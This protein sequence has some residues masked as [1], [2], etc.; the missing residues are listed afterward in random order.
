MEDF[1]P[2]QLKRISQLSVIAALQCEP[3]NTKGTQEGEEYLRPRSH[4]IAASPW[5]QLKRPQDVKN[6]GYWPQD[7]CNANE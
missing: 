5:S 4:Q 2:D 7:C 6:T 3:V 1:L